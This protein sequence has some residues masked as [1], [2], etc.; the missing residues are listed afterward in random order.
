MSHSS[1]EKINAIQVEFLKDPLMPIKGKIYRHYKGNLYKVEG[2][3]VDES[4]ELIQVIYSD[5]TNNFIIPWSRPFY[6]W[7]ELVLIETE[8]GATKMVHR[9]ELSTTHCTDE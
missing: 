4:T 8:E 7:S 2:F 9:F 5:I 6:E 3:S 1:R